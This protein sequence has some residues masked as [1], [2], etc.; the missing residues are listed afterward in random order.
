MDII[1][2][3]N[4]TSL[5]LCVIGN[6]GVG[7]STLVERITTGK[8]N[9]ITD[10]TIGIGFRM[11]KTRLGIHSDLETTFW[12]FGGEKRFWTLHPA[13]C[14]GSHGGLLVYDLSR[15]TL[16]KDLDWWTR[17][18]RKNTQPNTPL[19]LVGSKLDLLKNVNLSHLEEKMN[20]MCEELG[21]KKFY[22][23]S[24]KNGSKIRDLTMD[25]IKEMLEYISQNDNDL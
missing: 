7:K 5:K 18:W 21:L 24:S 25:V 16:Q 9:S 4:S 8:F 19:F 3:S 11:I 22:I 2:N 6:G 12:D 1:N 20:N 17:M 13:L 10:M 23:I 14:R 15:M